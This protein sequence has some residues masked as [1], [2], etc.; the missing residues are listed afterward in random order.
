LS[1]PVGPY[2]P[3]VSAGGLVVCSGQIGLRSTS[4]GP[5]LVDGGVRAQA[6]Q[7]LENAGALLAS[8]GIGWEDVFKTTAFLAD[9]SDYAAFNEVYVEVLGDNRPARSV[10]AVSG[11]PI[12]ALVEVEVWAT[13]RG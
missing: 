6:R 1:T 4:G 9:I 2:T 13:A 5:V 11:L 12:G 8:E 7:A 10:V 3:V